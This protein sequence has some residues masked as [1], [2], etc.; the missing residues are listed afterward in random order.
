[1]SLAPHAAVDRRTVI[2]WMFTAAAALSVSDHTL[3]AADT[4]SVRTPGGKG[5][6]SDPDLLKNYVPGELWP[7]TLSGSQRA[8]ATKL[9]DLIIPA[10]AT[11]PS[12][13]S[14]GVV[15]FIDEWISAPYP[16]HEKDRRL[17]LEGLAWLDAES[18]KR[19]GRPFADLVLG[20]Q[21]ALCDDI[22]YV[23]KARAELAKGA[24][25]FR[26]FR[27]LTAGGYYTTPAGMKAIGYTG[28]VPLATFDGPPESLLQKLGLV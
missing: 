16:A 25:F 19:F 28:N 8:A 18:A 2:K 3:F 7:L 27:D 26:R 21:T 1:M 23:P 17:I 10:D 12:A 15:D 11:S 20:Q 4:D 9:C 6:G 22:C 14:V 5:Y 13:S 24:E